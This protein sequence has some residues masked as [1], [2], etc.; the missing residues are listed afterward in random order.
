M[1]VNLV[2]DYSEP[3]SLHVLVVSLRKCAV[4]C[5]FHN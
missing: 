4:L 1:Y 3:N 5:N 2:L